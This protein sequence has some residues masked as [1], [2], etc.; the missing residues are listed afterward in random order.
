VR[1]PLIKDDE[2][3][4]E[5]GELDGVWELLGIWKFGGTVQRRGVRVSLPKIGSRGDVLFFGGI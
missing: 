3:G 2:M 5:L 1:R 4:W